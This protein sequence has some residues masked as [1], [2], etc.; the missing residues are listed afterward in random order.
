[1]LEKNEVESIFTK[2]N[3][4]LK[5]HFLLTSGRHSD[6]YM[7]CARLF[8]KAQYSE[9]LCKELAEEFKNDSVEIVIGPAVG[10]IILAYE[11]SRHLKVP[12][13][14]AERVDGKFKLRRNFEIYENANVL[15]VEDVVTT[16]GSV[17]EVM[18]IVKHCGGNVIGVGCIVD[19]SD[20]KA[21]FGVKFKSVYSTEVISY[22]SDQ[23]PIC[24][25]GLPLIKPGSRK[26]SVNDLEV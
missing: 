11:V 13:V 18:E 14:F 21:E 6:T 7:Q 2:T 8:E 12:N 24:A 22:E 20:G 10:A 4:L 17:R 5:G 26:I 25:T 15:V 23:C 16:G 9:L 1:M 3:V 19:R